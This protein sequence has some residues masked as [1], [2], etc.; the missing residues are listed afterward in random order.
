MSERVESTAEKKLNYITHGIGL[1]LSIVGFYYLLTRTYYLE[2]PDKLFSSVVYGLSLIIMYC[3][4]TL[5]HYFIDT[6][7]SSALQKMDHISIY[8]LI[9]GSYT[10]GLIL[11]LQYSL[12]MEIFFIIWFTTLIGT[13]HKIFFFKYYKKISLLIYLVMGWLIVIDFGAI[14]ESFS[15]YS[16]L[17]MVSG[18]MFYTIGTI[19]YAQDKL[20]YNHVIWHLFVMAGSACHFFMISSII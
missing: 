6:R 19:F 8:L 10:P 2:S 11:K 18:G 9:A 20:R 17:L 5:Y 3:S 15:N 16:I 12:G 1:I 4:S 13:I 7:F 14:M